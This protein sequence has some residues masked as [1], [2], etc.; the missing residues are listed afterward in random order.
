MP[1]QQA[2]RRW[3]DLP[4][5]AGG[6]VLHRLELLE[7]LPVQDVRSWRAGTS[8]GW[9]RAAEVLPRGAILQ[10]QHLTCCRVRLLRAAGSRPADR[11][12]ATVSVRC[13]PRSGGCDGRLPTRTID[14]WPGF[15][16]R[17]SPAVVPAVAPKR[18]PSRH[19]VSRA[20]LLISQPGLLPGYQRRRQITGS[21]HQAT[22][23]EKQPR[24]TKQ[25]RPQPLPHRRCRQP[26]WPTRAGRYPNA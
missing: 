15:M 20:W 17:S 18:A 26:R 7:R 2:S 5:S 11:R 22:Q 19:G 13:L 8:C 3:S 1:R 16:T 14:A 24:Q 21:N 6:L 12:H 9:P 25:P 23:R 10:D 4:E